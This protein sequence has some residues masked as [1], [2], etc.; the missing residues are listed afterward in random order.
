MLR[1]YCSMKSSSCISVFSSG[2]V[3][4]RLWNPSGWWPGVDGMQSV[5]RFSSVAGLC[6][7]VET[8]GRHSG[9]DG[10]DLFDLLG[11]LKMQCLTLRGGYTKVRGVPSLSTA[12]AHGTCLQPGA[13]WFLDVTNQEVSLDRRGCSLHGSLLPGVVLAGRAVRRNSGA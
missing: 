12:A 11:S 5:P 7:V 3:L 13:A 6:C 4:A 1:N 2:L 10:F 9:V 8:T